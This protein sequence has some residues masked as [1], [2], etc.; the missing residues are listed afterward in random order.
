MK[1]FKHYPLLMLVI[2]ILFAACSPQTPVATEPVQ[3]VES[4][5]EAVVDGRFPLV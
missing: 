2:A 5:A 4:A 3:N 1:Q